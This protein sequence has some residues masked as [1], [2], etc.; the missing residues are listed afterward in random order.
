M[1]KAKLHRGTVITVVRPVNLLT[2]KVP[3]DLK[4]SFLGP[5]TGGLGT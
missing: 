1:P 2:N 5:V 4:I 3:A